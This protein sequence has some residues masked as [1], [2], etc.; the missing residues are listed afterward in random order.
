MLGEVDPLIVE[1][2]LATGASTEE[3]GEALLVAEDTHGFGELPHQPSSPRVAEVCAVL[4][5]LDVLDEDA[6]DDDGR[7]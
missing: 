2:I 5:E 4:D 3:I 7:S 1:R 6:Y